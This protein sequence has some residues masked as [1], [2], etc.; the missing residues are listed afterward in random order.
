MDEDDSILAKLDAV[1]PIQKFDAFPKVQPT[2]KAKSSGGGFWTIVA[3]VAS[4]LLVMNDLTEYIWGWPDHEFAVDTQVAKTMLLNVDMVVAM[5]CHYIS[6]DLRDAV[7]ERLYLSNG[8]RRDGT[9]FD[10]NQ[11][12]ALQEWQWRRQAAARDVVTA[13]RAERGLFAWLWTTKREFPPTYNYRPAGSACRVF[14]SVEVKKVTANLHVT[15]L[16]H[17]Y[18]GH[19]HT[20]HSLMNLSHIITEFS[21]G[22]YIPDIVQPLDYSYEKTDKPF[23]IFQYFLTVVPTTY[24]ASPSRSVRTNQYSVTHYTKYIEHGQGA[25]GIFF[26]YDIDPMAIEVHQRTTYF[27]DFFIRVVGVIGGVWV[28]AR[29]AFKIGGKAAEVVTGSRGDDDQVL[30]AESTSRKS[31]WSGGSLNKRSSRMGGWDSDAG[32]ISAVSSPGLVTPGSGWGGAP[33]SAGPYSPALNSSTGAGGFPP[34][35]PYP[36]PRTPSGGAGWTVQ[37][38]SATSPHFPPTS[39]LP[40][41]PSVYSPNS[42]SAS[43]SSIPTQAPPSPGGPYSPGP[44]PQSFHARTSSGLNPNRVS[45]TSPPQGFRSSSGGSISEKKED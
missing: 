16:G 43:Q 44:R 30:V 37:P 31:R 40:P 42:F 26:R 20:D 18:A 22:P 4:L 19:E 3:I 24:Y 45:L 2:Y 29:W 21:F 35:S 5:P 10:P 39:P 8:F 33:I 34:T 27:H 12:G 7:G 25:P 9:T 17:G 15:T 41:T 28:C 36:Y 38:P 11:A 14:G 13:S 1:A 23:T 6:V 32:S